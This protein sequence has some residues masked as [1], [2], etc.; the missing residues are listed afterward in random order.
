VSLPRAAPSSIEGTGIA[1]LDPAIGL[2]AAA[3]RRFVA[4]A[5]APRRTATA[6]RR[7]F[8]SPAKAGRTLRAAIP[9]G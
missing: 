4:S 3:L 7:A 9:R 8:S 6:R 2:D 5:R 1:R